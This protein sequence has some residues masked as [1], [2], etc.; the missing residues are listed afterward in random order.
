MESQEEPSEILPLQDSKRVIYLQQ[1]VATELIKHLISRNRF[2]H[3][4]KSDQNNIFYTKG[5]AEVGLQLWEPL[6]IVQTRP[7]RN[8]NLTE[9]WQ[10]SE[11]YS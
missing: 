3:V 10:T 11:R 4:I 2:P 9:P 8:C 1:M 7:L 5:E 6:V